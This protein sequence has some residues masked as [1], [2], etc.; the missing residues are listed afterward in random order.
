ML[1]FPI[2]RVA[3]A[4]LL[5][6]YHYFRMDL[7]QVLSYVVCVTQSNWETANRS[8]LPKKRTGK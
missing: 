3:L 2:E 5:Y 8:D 6:V 1:G 7:D 4:R